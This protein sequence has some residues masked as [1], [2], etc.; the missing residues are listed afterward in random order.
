LNLKRKKKYNF[1]TLKVI[2]AQ[3]DRMV[4]I[5]GGQHLNVS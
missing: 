2:L 4:C 1:W 5:G 3:N